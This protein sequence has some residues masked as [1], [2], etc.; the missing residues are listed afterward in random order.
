L[1]SCTEGNKRLRELITENVPNYFAAKTKTDKGRVIIDIIEKLRRDSPS[2]VGLAKLNTKTGRWSFIGYDKAKDK[3]GHALRKA[4]QEIQEKRSS[5]EEYTSGKRKR[6]EPTEEQVGSDEQA[7]QRS[8]L[9]A[10]CREEAELYSNSQHWAYGNE[11]KAY[12]QNYSHH[13]PPHRSHQHYYV[14]E[15]K[16][17]PP[18]AYTHGSYHFYPPPPPLRVVPYHSHTGMASQDRE[19]SSINEPPPQHMYSPTMS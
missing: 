5:S 10:R 19:P 15:Y 7:L 14:V 3:I 16:H 18:T 2:G 1:S 13:A 17:P 9:P 8:T 11:N 12:E 6:R 4:S